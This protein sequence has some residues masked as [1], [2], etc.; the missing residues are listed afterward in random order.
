MTPGV[1]IALAVT[2]AVEVPVVSLVYRREP[3]RMAIACAL[4]T[5][6]TN[7][8]MN[9]WLLHAVSSYASYLLVGELCAT[10][11]EGLVY[12]AASRQHDVGRA[13]VASGLA[14]A[15]SFIAGLLLF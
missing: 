4:A 10:V 3:A 6:A 12:I 13:L 9:A 7:L 14:N 11:V 5:S 8:A 2:L 1:G 15:A